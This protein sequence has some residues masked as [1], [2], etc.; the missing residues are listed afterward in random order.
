MNL[1]KICPVCGDPFTL[2]GEKMCDCE[3]E[4]CYCDICD[5]VL[6]LDEIYD[7]RCKDCTK[8]LEKF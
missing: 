4:E 2:D 7:G 8:E 6:M 1:G 5:N 3:M